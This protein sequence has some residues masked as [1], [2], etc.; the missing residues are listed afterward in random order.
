MSDQRLLA[1]PPTSA[2]AESFE[3][4]V[5][6]LGRVPRGVAA[7]TV[8]GE[9][10][11]SGLLGRGGA[12]FPVGRK[13]RR[14]AE[15]DGGRAVVVAN[16]AEGEQASA[17]DRV[18][19]AYRP[20]LVLDGA[21][22]A[23]E[24]I[25]ADEVV[26]YVGRE[27]ESAV[28]A[29]RRAIAD[30]RGETSRS[31]RLVEA[32]VGY[33]AGEASA[34]V[35]YLDHR[36][37]RPT[38]TPPRVSER[39]VKGRPTLVQNVESLAYAALIARASAGW[40]RETGTGPTRGTALVTVSGAVG[41]EGV[42]EI[43]IGTT[44]GDLAAMS[45]ARPASVRAALLGGYF[46][47]WADAD[48]V[49]DLPLDPVSLA[50]HDLAFGCGIVGLLPV[51]RCGVAATAEILGYL[52]TESA[53]QCGPCVFGLRAIADAVERLARLAARGG[54]LDDLTRFAGLVAGRGACH[55]PDG[56]VQHLLSALAVF[57]DEFGLHAAGGCTARRAR[58]GAA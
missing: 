27:H 45:G 1:G 14:L 16:G 26:V 11:A 9:L 36:D 24:T 55:H 10:E 20:H 13:W 21:L 54:D 15:R 56:A 8:I 53:G 32:P 44:V 19:M 5:A 37:P 28:G 40:Y 12:G 29:M 4:H 41:R 42:R 17:K 23:A 6:R 2:G 35:H 47:T 7:D 52:A 31:V 39:G 22:L 58:A 25:D 43:A 18:L 46:G 30:R 49:W 38:T 3:A 33:V 51:E 48:T 34:V 57:G 50:E